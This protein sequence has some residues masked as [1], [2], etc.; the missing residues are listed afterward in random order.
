VKAL[1]IH[2]PNLNLLGRREMSVYGTDT[3]EQVNEQIQ[4]EAAD[5]G[6]E[7]EAHQTAREGEIVELLHSGI[8]RVDGCLLN[9]GAYSHTS[10]AIADAIRAVPYPV[11]EVHLSN[12]HARE[13]WRSESVTAR[14]SRGLVA[15]FGP[16]SYVLALR[17]LQRV[18][19]ARERS[20]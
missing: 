7:V 17:G 10:R 18:L 8:D 12:I 5:L 6:I 11:I 14:E 16:G 3:L 9:P 20:S 2:G 19:G 1:L 4:K 13:P 15:G